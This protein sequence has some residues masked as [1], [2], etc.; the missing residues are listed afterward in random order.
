MCNPSGIAFV[1]RNL[2][3]LD[4][5]AKRVLEVGSRNVNGSARSLIESLDPAE[6]IGV[7]IVPG[8]GVDELCDVVELRA[9]FGE[10]SF[11]LV[12]S[13]ELIEHVK[14][15]RAAI[16]NLKAVLK[17]GG[18]ILLTT[19][20]SGFKVHGYPWDYWRYE[21]SDMARIFADFEH[22][23]IKV[24][25][26]SPGVFVKAQRPRSP[27]SHAPLAGIALYS[28]VTRRRSQSFSARSEALF[29]L[30]HTAHRLYRWLLPEWVRAPIKR[31]ATRRP[32]T[33]FRK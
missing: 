3:A 30:R 11:D 8:P 16:E 10:A 25:P 31:V 13:T 18:W 32:E 28:V 22:V 21:P 6:Y 2:S 15:W 14:D 19:R 27:H 5:Q 17:P 20:S 9:C 4:V 12:V 26:R 23:Q 29:K 33:G 7:D 24:D 1:G